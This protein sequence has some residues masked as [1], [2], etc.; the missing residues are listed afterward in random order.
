MSASS[1]VR[2]DDLPD[3]DNG[4]AAGEDGL[5]PR[6]GSLLDPKGIDIASAVAEQLERE[7]RERQW[8]S[9][10]ALLE[11]ATDVLQEKTARLRDSGDFGQRQSWMMQQQPMDAIDVDDIVSKVNP[12]FRST[13]TLTQGRSKVQDE[14]KQE[15]I[16]P[17]LPPQH[18]HTHTHTHT[19]N[20]NNNRCGGGS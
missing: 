14:P 17:P 16:T 12:T 3:D 4:A 9:A 20:N 2:D 11:M 6:L 8:A 13:V 10:D 7:R 1:P 5:G 19:N 18:T 15:L